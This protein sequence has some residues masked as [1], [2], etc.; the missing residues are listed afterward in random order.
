MMGGFGTGLLIVGNA[1]AAPWG[2]RWLERLLEGAGLATS[3]LP[4]PTLWLVQLFVV[5]CVAFHL[6]ERL[7]TPVIADQGPGPFH[8]GW[9][10]DL[11]GA[12]VD[13][14]V[15]ASLAELAGLTMVLMVPALDPGGRLA[16]WPRAAQFAAVFLANDFGRY[17]LHRWYHRSDFLWRFHRVHHTARQMSVLTNFR[18]HLLEAI[19]KYALLVL[20]FRILGADVWVLVAYSSLDLVKGFWQH[21]NLRT[22]IGRANWVL[23]SPELHWW[24]HSPD[25]RGHRANYG[26]TLSIWDRL[27]GTFYWPRG[28]WPE[29]IGIRGMDVFPDD[30]L[31][32]FASMLRTDEEI[33]RA[34][35]AGAQTARPEPVGEEASRG[36]SGPPLPL[37]PQAGEAYGTA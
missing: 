7:G 4:W 15:V 20:P 3:T 11:T 16:R 26:S 2:L 13:G 25:P 31:G 9:F 5:S 12:V 27:F 29:Q 6:L 21:A 37:G 1:N 14:P 30:Y 8:R 24:H 33:R 17:W 28:R 10:A 34:S 36:G 23:N 32:R 35:A 18:L 22:H 19:P